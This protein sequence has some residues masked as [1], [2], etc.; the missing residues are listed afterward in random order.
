[1]RAGRAVREG[2]LVLP[3]REEIREIEEGEAYD[4]LGIP[5]LLQMDDKRAKVSYMNECINET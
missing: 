4:Y 2:P 5:Q 1:M 3:S